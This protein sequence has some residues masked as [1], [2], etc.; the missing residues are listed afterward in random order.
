MVVLGLLGMAA[1]MTVVGTTTALHHT[2]S[3]ISEAVE[4]V[5]AAQELEIRLLLHNRTADTASRRSVEQA[6]RALIRSMGPYAGD[7]RE[8]RLLAEVEVAIERYL[9]HDLGPFGHGDDSEADDGR[10]K[11]VEAAI[12]AIH[13]LV[14]LNIQQARDLRIKSERWDLWASRA[15]LMAA[16]V[17]IV[18]IGM[19]IV[20]LQRWALQPVLGLR[21]TIERLGNGQLEAR[22][23]VTGPAEIREIAERFNSMAQALDRKRR[24]QMSFLASVAH[25]IRNPLSAMSL[26]VS[27]LERPDGDLP[28]V[29]TKRPVALVKRQIDRL[30]RL[31]GDLM[32]AAQFEAG[33]MDL[34]REPC[35]LRQ[36]AQDV[37]DMFANTSRAHRLECRL[38][39]APVCV[40]GDPVR[41]DQV[42]SN[43]V[44]NAIK[45]SPAGGLVLVTVEQ[46]RSAAL[47][48]VS[49]QGEGILPEDQTLL[50]DPFRRAESARRSPGAGLGLFIT[51][52]I[53]RAHGGQIDLVSER[54]RGSTFTVRLPAEASARTGLQAVVP[55]A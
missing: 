30:Q 20:W 6:V 17:L 27:A 28:S 29:K 10:E 47:V 2:T 42:L 40:P 7:L 37:C 16:L 14:V 24:T 35:D 23:P 46:E 36:L 49:D 3:T 48:R 41:L 15:G 51:R 18:G 12:A 13:R 34:R 54:G 9:A 45:Y 4:S 25:D 19:V 33:A 53:V 44:S 26:S 38:P 11:S 55:R 31:A 50:F 8:Q 43:L 1:A 22:A 32:D 5:R 39:A 21:D 52:Q